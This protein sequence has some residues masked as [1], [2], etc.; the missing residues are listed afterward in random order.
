VCS[1]QYL[2]DRFM[3]L[4]A[5]KGSSAQTLQ[6]LDHAVPKHGE[7]CNKVC[8]GDDVEVQLAGVGQRP[9]LHCNVARAPV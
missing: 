7:A 8:V 9:Y 1:A 3:A 2:A 5:L 4:F 6:V